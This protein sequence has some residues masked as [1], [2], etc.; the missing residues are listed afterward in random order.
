MKSS[1]FVAM[2][3]GAIIGAY[4]CALV[5]AC[6]AAKPGKRSVKP[7]T[8]ALESQVKSIQTFPEKPG[9]RSEE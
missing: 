2:L 3:G 5:C 7:L 8:K 4:H 9:R 6:K 1:H